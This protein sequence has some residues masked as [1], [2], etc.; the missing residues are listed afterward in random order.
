MPKLIIQI[1]CLNE[2][3]ALPATLASLPRRLDGID[4]I[5]ILIIDDGST[6]G[7]AEVAR[8]CGVNHIIRFSSHRG[9]ARA[10]AEGL[11]ACLRLGADIIV[12]TDADGQYPAEDIPCLIA[13]ILRGEA[14]VVI[15]NRGVDSVPH[16]SPLKRLLQRLGSRMVSMLSGIEVGDVTS[17][18]R[19]YNREAALR[20][21]IITDFTYTLETIIQS[22]TKP[23]T[24]VTVPTR[25]N[26][27]TRPSRLFSGVPDY[28]RRQIPSM[29]RLYMIYQPLKTF[30]LLAA[31]LLAAGMLL[32]LRFVYFWLFE[33][34][35]GH[36]QSLILAAILLIVGF[37]IFTLGLVADLLGANR[38]LLEDTL[39]RVRRIELAH[40]A[41]GD[42]GES[43]EAAEGSGGQV[44]QGEDQP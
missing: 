9:L 25:S 13:P 5:E 10:F 31:A 29:L 3:Q 20:L 40:L 42:A 2:S 11:G 21:N 18:F 12:H 30:T 27:P 36:I 26:P 35:A 38:R 39:Y 24:I 22:G 19:A 17:G 44:P 34:G 1:P 7:T 32:G 41:E 23:I 8:Q 16:F 28:L 43:S 4:Q 14:D 37:Q 15:G 33:S 6:D